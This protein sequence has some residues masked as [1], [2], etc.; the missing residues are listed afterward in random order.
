M[1]WGQTLKFGTP[2]KYVEMTVRTLEWKL[3][4]LPLHLQDPRLSLYY[5]HKHCVDAHGTS[6]V[7]RWSVTSPTRALH[8][9][10]HD[11]NESPGYQESHGFAPIPAYITYTCNFNSVIQWS[12]YTRWKTMSVKRK[13]IVISMKNKSNALKRLDPYESLKILLEN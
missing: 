11:S 3:S 7:W 1:L 5:V 10:S 4:L 9:C 13:I 12:Y 2:T 6:S 8:F